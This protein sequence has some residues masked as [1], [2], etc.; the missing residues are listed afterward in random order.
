[1]EVPGTQL[2]RIHSSIVGQDYD[3]YVIIPRNY[4]DTTRTF[5]VLYLLDAQYDFPLMNGVYG[6]QYYDGFVPDVITV[7]ITWAG[8]HA[9]YDTLR[10]RDYTP[11]P[12]KQ[13]PYTGNASKFLA[14]I[15]NG[16]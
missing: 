9:N 5:P 11:T 13:V 3:L 7:G 16:K 6:E 14:F 2:L 4:H 8:E 10:A 12:Y 1:M 15:K